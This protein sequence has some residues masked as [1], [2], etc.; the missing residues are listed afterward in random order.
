MV[1]ENSP[2]FTSFQRTNQDNGKDI[3]LSHHEQNLEGK[4]TPEKEQEEGG[5]D[6]ST[7]TATIDNVSP[8]LDRTLTVIDKIK[9][10]YWR[11]Y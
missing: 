6:S 3:L 10:Y 5:D 4:D 7:I 8:K 1:D 2:I 9:L 11:K